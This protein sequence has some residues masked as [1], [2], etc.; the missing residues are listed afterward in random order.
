MEDKLGKQNI[1][2]DALSPR[3]AT[4]PSLMALSEITFLIFDQIRVEIATNEGAGQLI[5]SIQVGQLS[6]AWIF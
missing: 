6:Q 1:V 3:D 2:V 4:E 5:S